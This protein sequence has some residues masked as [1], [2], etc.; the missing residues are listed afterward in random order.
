MKK[1]K[2]NYT[3]QGYSYIKATKENCYN[4]GGMAVCDSCNEEMEDMY[5]IFILGQALCEKCF[6]EWIEHSQRYEED[7]YLQRQNQVNWYRRY[8]FEVEE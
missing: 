7:L 4:W 3:K 8:G 6:K 5:L 1:V 2:L